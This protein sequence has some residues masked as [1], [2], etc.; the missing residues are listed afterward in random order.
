MHSVVRE[1]KLFSVYR[2]QSFA[3]E[4]F[5]QEKYQKLHRGIGEQRNPNL[6]QA[7]YIGIPAETCKLRVF[8]G[9]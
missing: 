7:A 5:S 9:V 4:E 6:W 1:Q 8:L 3:V 2:A